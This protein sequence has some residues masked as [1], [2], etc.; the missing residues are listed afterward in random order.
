MKKIAYFLAGLLLWSSVQGQPLPDSVLQAYAKAEKSSDKGQVLARSLGLRENATQQTVNVLFQLHAYFKKQQD[1][2]GMDYTTLFIASLFERFGNFSDALKLALP[3]LPHFEQRQD[4]FGILRSYLAIGNSI[5]NSE[6]VEQSLAYYK[7]ALPIASNF[8]DANIK[9]TLLNNIADGYK[10]LRLF[11]SALLYAQEAVRLLEQKGNLFTLSTALSTLGEIYLE[12]Q[13]HEIGRS[14][15]KKSIAYAKEGKNR[16]AVAFIL[17]ELSRSYLKTQDFDS[18]IAYAQSALTWAVP[19]YK[20]VMMDAYQLL[21]K[22][23]EQKDARDSVSKYIRL[24]MVIKDTLF[25]VEKNRNIQVMNFQEQMRQ[26]ELEAALQK[27]QEQ[28]RHNLQYSAILIGLVSFVILFLMLSRTVIVKEKFIRFFGV[29]GLLAVFEFI[30]LFVHPYLDRLTNH[31][32][33][34]ML[35]IL[36]CIAALLIPLHH[37]LEHWVIHKLVEKNNRIRLAAAR[38]T[39]EQLK[40]SITK[41]PAERS[42]DP[43]HEV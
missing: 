15:A 12:K 17:N 41:V 9:G 21:Y 8:N 23:Y 31:S 40:G 13:D 37:K 27:E 43:Q 28:R 42:T 25:S 2:V 20:V 38:K 18:S 10:R 26:Q 19:D 39:I 5:I 24:S 29:L 4:T 3:I 22:N 30:N 36:M 34:L 6:N 32:P 14:I 16:Y 7:K 35:M 11:D 33:V 1:Q